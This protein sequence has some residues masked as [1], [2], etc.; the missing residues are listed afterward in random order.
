MLVENST[1]GDDST[2]KIKAQTRELEIN[3]ATDDVQPQGKAG[4]GV[5]TLSRA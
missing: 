3:F 4:V 2:V 1:I 5:I